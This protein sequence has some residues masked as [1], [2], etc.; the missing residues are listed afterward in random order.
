MIFFIFIILQTCHSCESFVIFQNFRQ[1]SHSHF[2]NPLIMLILLLAS[3]LIT[4]LVCFFQPHESLFELLDLGT[5]TTL[6]CSDVLK[7]HSGLLLLVI[8]KRVASKSSC[9]V[10][11]ISASTHTMISCARWMFDGVHTTG[12]WIVEE[13]RG[14]CWHYLRR[15]E[16]YA[17]WFLRVILTTGI[18]VI[19]SLV[20]D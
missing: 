10:E 13:I 15:I 7:R 20:L 14:H 1:L 9:V 8:N 3:N 2:H 16:T 6:L 11:L 18:D 19:T 17:G 12:E 5:R 4:F